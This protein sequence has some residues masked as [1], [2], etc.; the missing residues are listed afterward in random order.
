MTEGDKLKL[1]PVGEDK[2]LEVEVKAISNNGEYTAVK[3]GRYYWACAVGE[4][5]LVPLGG[6]YCK[7]VLM[8]VE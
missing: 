6:N 8:I 7:R 5:S 2:I 1:R 3:V 4:N